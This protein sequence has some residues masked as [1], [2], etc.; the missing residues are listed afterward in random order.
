M[1]AASL[2]FLW[3]TLCRHL[4]SEWSLNEQYSYGWFVPFFAAYLFWLRWEDRP[5]GRGPPEAPSPKLQAPTWRNGTEAD[6]RS[7]GGNQ[8]RGIA[9]GIAILGLLILLPVRLFEVANPDWRPLGWIHAFAVIAITFA[10]IYFAGG[11]RWTK[12][13]S[14]PILF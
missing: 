9:I 6:Q 10:A 13:F 4:G 12:H 8:R 3:F 14:F 5:D 7:A 11:W 2:G 1:L